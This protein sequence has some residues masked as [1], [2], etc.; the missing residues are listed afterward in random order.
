MVEE[1][2]LG[3]NRPVAE[4]IPEFTGEG[5][6]A[7]MVHHLLTHTSGLRDL[8]ADA[9]ARQ[10]GALTSDDIFAGR[11]LPHLSDFLQAR[12]DAPLWKPP[13]EEMS[14]CG[15]GYDL[16]GEIVARVSGQP[17]AAFVQERICGPLGMA[18]THFVVPEEVRHRIALRPEEAVG[19]SIL[20]LR[21]L[22]E[23]PYAGSGAYG[24]AQDLAIF[25]QMFLNQGSYGDVRILSPATVAEM[26]RNQIPGISAR[27][28]E[29][30][31][32]EACWGLGWRVPGNNR[33]IRDGSL[34]SGRSFEHGGF[35][36]VALWVDPVYELVGA[37]FS[38]VPRHLQ[39]F[40]PNGTPI[41]S[42]IW[43]WRQLSM[44]E[45]CSIGRGHVER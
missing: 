23:E 27:W 13:G 5:K 39:P 28:G 33:G 25:G 26:T 19:A 9:C 11:D 6:H 4:Y 35:G 12:Y 40:A 3:L 43:P 30:S 8:E 14:Y 42:R 38:V 10:K 34:R 17:L 31:F 44:L 41:S 18:G 22:Q 36:G 29:E 1:G 7:V 2:L 15:F 20:N 32:P 16:L 21:G 37:Y 45:K 24:T